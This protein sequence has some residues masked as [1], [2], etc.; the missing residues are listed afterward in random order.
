MK[1]IC[2]YVKVERYIAQWLAATMGLPVRFPPQS[3]ENEVLRRLLTVCPKNVEPRLPGD[4]DVAIVIPDSSTRPPEYYNY[5]GR[6]S[7]QMMR[8]VIDSLFRLHLWWGCVHLIAT[9]GELNAGLDAWCASVGI[10]L[11]NREAVRQKFY[12]MRRKYESQQIILGKKYRKDYHEGGIFRT[13]VR[14][15]K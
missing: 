13:T 7:E 3:F 10:S 14:K 6:R 11:D 1:D 2:V 8:T 9:P 12:R 5:L 15:D 4:G